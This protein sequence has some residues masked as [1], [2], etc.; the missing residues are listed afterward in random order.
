M[1]DAVQAAGAGRMSGWRN[2]ENQ[3]I[4]QIERRAGNTTLNRNFHNCRLGRS[5]R[6]PSTAPFV[7]HPKGTTQGVRL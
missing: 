4:T 6:G 5:T 7:E 2:A 3:A 1:T